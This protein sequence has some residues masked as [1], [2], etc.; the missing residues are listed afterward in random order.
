MADPRNPEAKEAALQ[1]LVWA[2]EE[3]EKAGDKS[4]A[5]HA[6]RAID[7]LREAH[8]FPVLKRQQAHD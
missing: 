4:A 3:L 8:P 7:A 2:L 6:R 5:K 1:Y